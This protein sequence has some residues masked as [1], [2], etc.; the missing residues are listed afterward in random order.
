MTK[1]LGPLQPLRAPTAM[2]AMGANAFAGIT[3]DS[4]HPINGTNK[5]HPAGKLLNMTHYPE[6]SY[7]YTLNVDTKRN[8]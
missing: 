2:F 4:I 8:F 3:A 1:Q 6:A 7:M 5:D